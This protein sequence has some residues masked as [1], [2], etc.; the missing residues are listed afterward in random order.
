[1]SFESEPTQEHPTDKFFREL[2]FEGLGSQERSYKDRTILL[3]DYFDQPDV[4]PSAKYMYDLIRSGNT[5]HPD[6]ELSRETMISY[7][8]VFSAAVQSGS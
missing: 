6:Y 8:E 1:M 3:R 2:G 4:A 5:A 7:C